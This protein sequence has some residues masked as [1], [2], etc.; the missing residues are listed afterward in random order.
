M[1][2]VES[3]SMARIII[4]S[5]MPMMLNGCSSHLVTE[6]G[7]VW[8]G[9]PSDNESNTSWTAKPTYLVT[10]D[11]TR[12]A[13]GLGS[14][15]GVEEPNVRWI[16]DRHGVVPDHDTNITDLGHGVLRMM[17]RFQANDPAGGWW[18]GDQRT[19]RS[20]RQRAEVKGLGPHQK[21]GQTYEY[22][23]TFRT[24]PAFHAT[25]RFCHIMQIKATDGDKGMPLVTLSLRRG[26]VGV[27]QYASAKDGFRTA[28]T[29]KWSP[30]KWTRVRFRLNVSREGHGALLLSVDGGAFAGVRDVAIYRP[31]A[32]DYRPKWGLYRAIVP[33][34]HDDWVEHRD[35]SVKRLS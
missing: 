3:K 35:L 28:Q 26:G 27:L 30:G 22:G 24:D 13:L 20:D 1:G 7:V 15:E 8:A 16:V 25:D 2:F 17:L 32:S 6:P 29:F 33:T 18:D 12:R 19:D 14:L 11:G 5:A 31:G 21:D 23:T 9:A 4:A 10:A 34:L